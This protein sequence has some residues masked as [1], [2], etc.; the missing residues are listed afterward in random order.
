MIKIKTKDGKVILGLEKE[1]IKRLK[2][3][4]PIHIKGSD[5]GIENDIYIVYGNTKNDIMKDLN[6][7]TPKVVK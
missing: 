4:K 6:L 7:T 2:Q 1:N 3:G 5:L